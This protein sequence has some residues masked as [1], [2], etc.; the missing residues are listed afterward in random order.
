RVGQVIVQM[1]LDQNHLVI[2]MDS[3]EAAIRRLRVR[4][5]PYIFGDADSQLVLEKAHIEKAKAL[6]IAL[7]DPNSTRLLLQQALS[8]NPNLDTIARSHSDKEIDILTKM[9]AKEV[10]QPEFEAALELGSHLLNT[11]GEP[12]DKVRNI[13]HT[14]RMAR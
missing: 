3:S 9:G 4:K 12:E 8:I 13:V 5:I 6:A 10:V 1:L 7:P 2:V 14:M 11:L